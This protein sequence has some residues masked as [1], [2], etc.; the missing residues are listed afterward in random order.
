VAN[1]H[2]GRHEGMEDRKC[3][4]MSKR[5]LGTANPLSGR[6][7]LRRKLRITRALLAGKKLKQV[8]DGEGLSQERVR[9]IL[10]EVC[11]KA[12]K[13]GPRRSGPQ[14]DMFNIAAVRQHQ[15]FWLA[16]V[17]LLARQWGVAEDD[18]VDSDDEAL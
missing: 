5:A 2:V 3:L 13:A 6:D 18:C 11:F 14:H 17:S 4:G 15:R 7:L 10:H 8:G 9:Q 12:Y 16:R 1:A